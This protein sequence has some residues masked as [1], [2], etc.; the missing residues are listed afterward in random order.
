MKN[1]RAIL[2]EQIRFLI[3]DLKQ[4]EIKTIYAEN[5]DFDQTVEY[6]REIQ[7]DITEL[8][9]LTEKN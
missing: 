5:V 7:D 8:I 3:S 2:L 9:T 4:L 6:L 1:D